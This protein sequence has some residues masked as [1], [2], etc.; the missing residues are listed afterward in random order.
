MGHLVIEFGMLDVGYV[1]FFFHYPLGKIL[2]FFFRMEAPSLSLC[3]LGY[4]RVV[5]VYNLIFFD[6]VKSF[7]NLRLGY[8]VHFQ[9]LPWHEYYSNMLLLYLYVG[10]LTP[11]SSKS[12]GISLQSHLLIFAYHTYLQLVLLWPI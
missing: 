3:D 10:C 12:S 8:L 6:L 7:H 1:G 2:L 4:S 5:P 11:E 9:K